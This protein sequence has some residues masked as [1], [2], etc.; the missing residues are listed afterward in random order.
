MNANLGKISKIEGSTLGQMSDHGERISKG[1]IGSDVD[2]GG[3]G[4]KWVSL[5]EWVKDQ[6]TKRPKDQKTKRPKD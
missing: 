1:Y 5:L 6:K 3:L 2:C 4:G